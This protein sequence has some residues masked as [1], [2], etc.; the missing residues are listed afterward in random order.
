MKTAF[1]SII[2]A[3]SLY[4]TAHG[5]GTSTAAICEIVEIKGAEKQTTTILLSNVNDA[6]GDVQTFQLKL[7]SNYTGL[8]SK[9]REYAV[10]HFND[11]DNKLGFTTHADLTGTGVA[12]SQIYLPS[13]DNEINAIQTTCLRPDLAKP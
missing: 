13:V 3:L 9:M 5:F 4:S 6:H 10:I 8:V 1:S 7:F 2:L 11:L 12:Y